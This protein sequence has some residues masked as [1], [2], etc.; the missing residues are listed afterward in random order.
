MWGKGSQSS[1]SISIYAVPFA[2]YME[3]PHLDLQYFWVRSPVLP[4][5]FTMFM[6]WPHLDLNQGPTGYEPALMQ[7]L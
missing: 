3:W 6:E 7:F 1:V 5:P 4:F 2:I